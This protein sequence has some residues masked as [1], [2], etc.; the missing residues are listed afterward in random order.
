MDEFI[1]EVREDVRRDR[2]LELWRKYGKYA[3]GLVLAAIIAAAAVV[4]WRDYQQAQRAK[5]GMIYAEA[6]D[7]VREGQTGAAIAAFNNLAVDAGRG[8]A[9]L[10][11]LQQ[12][13]L[14]ARDGNGAGA[15]AIYEQLASDTGADRMFRDLALILLALNTAD[16][17]DPAE[18][19][20]RLE[21]LTAKD[22]PWRFSA[23]E[24][25]ALLAQNSGD[26]ARA[27]EIFKSLADD[28]TAPR[29]VR[30]RASAML[31]SLGEERR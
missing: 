19:S 1:R 28:V 27:E 23:L 11:R 10:A 25:T 14:L 3:I 16:T 22:N 5:H 21:P 18:L 4:G 24:V 30:A 31:A 8:Y 26:K 29:Q 15:A 9:E 20:R 7:L 12:A 6:L 13:A 17:A 2:A